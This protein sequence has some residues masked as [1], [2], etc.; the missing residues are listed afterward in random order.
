M[1]NFTWG[2][3]LLV[4]GMN[5]IIKAFF[6]RSW[7]FY[8]RLYKLIELVFD[9]IREFMDRVN[10]NSELS[11]DGANDSL[12][13]TLCARDAEITGPTMFGGIFFRQ[14]GLEECIEGV[15]CGLDEFPHSF[16]RQML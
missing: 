6:D 8:Y 15:H 1:S 7:D 4:H 10:E 14:T 3:D 9:D 12:S 11:F 13:F 2:G 5:E 16:C